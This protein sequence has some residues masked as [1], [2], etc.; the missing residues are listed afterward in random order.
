MVSVSASRS[1][2]FWGSDTDGGGGV[3]EVAVLSK[4]LS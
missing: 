2:L 4:V 3:D 1:A